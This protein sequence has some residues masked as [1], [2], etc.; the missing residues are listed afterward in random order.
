VGEQ[1]HARGVP[2]L[3]HVALHE[4]RSMAVRLA[5][6]GSAPT[7]IS[8]AGCRTR[9]SG[10]GLCRPTSAPLLAKRSIA[11]PWRERPRDLA[12]WSA[13]PAAT[14]VVAHATLSL[15]QP[16]LVVVARVRPGGIEGVRICVVKCGRRAAIVRLATRAFK[17]LRVTA[18]SLRPRCA[19][20]TAL[21]ARVASR[22]RAAIDGRHRS[23]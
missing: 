2:P 8:A 15:P 13:K 5:T 14:E 16:E 19:R 9:A 22:S 4:S 11:V 10:G 7:S 6:R 18:F 1:G 3:V 17:A 23:A 20:L 12:T 21:T